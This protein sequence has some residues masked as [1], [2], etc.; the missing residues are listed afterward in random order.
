[1]KKVYYSYKN[2]IED[3]RILLKQIEAYKP[4]AIVAVSNK[5]KAQKDRGY[6]L[7]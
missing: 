6:Y 2:F 5:K 3:S 4:D 1:M 7:F